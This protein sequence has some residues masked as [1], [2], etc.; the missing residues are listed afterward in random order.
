MG[1]KSA[2]LIAV[3]SDVIDAEANKHTGD[4]VHFGTR[5][6]NIHFALAAYVSTQ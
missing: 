4:N 5:T 2:K 6:A 1:Q 3:R